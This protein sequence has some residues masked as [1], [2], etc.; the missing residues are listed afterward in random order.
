[1]SLDNWERRS[2]SLPRKYCN[3]DE[4]KVIQLLR[5]KNNNKNNNN[6]TTSD[7]ILFN[8]YISLLHTHTACLLL[9]TLPY[10]PHYFHSLHDVIMTSP[11]LIYWKPNVLSFNSFPTATDHDNKYIVVRVNI[12]QHKTVL[13]SHNLSTDIIKIIM[14]YLINL[15]QLTIQ[16][17]FFCMIYKIFN[18]I[19]TYI[20]ICIVLLHGKQ[21]FFVKLWSLPTREKNLT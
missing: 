17:I 12:V 13:C 18:D 7:Y 21:K 15:V 9:F 14:S 2:L 20:Y 19:R 10:T 3:K 5:F 16:V 11:F 8:T 1:M 4:K 6:N